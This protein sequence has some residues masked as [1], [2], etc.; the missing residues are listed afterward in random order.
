MRII[1]SFT[2]VVQIFP[3]ICMAQIKK[4]EFFDAI[5]YR[6]KPNLESYG[7]KKMYLFYEEDLM[8]SDK[9]Q[10][11]GNSI[12]YGKIKTA[13]LRSMVNSNFP[14]CLDVESWQLDDEN[15]YNS[16]KIYLKILN[17]FKKI[18]KKSK[19]GFFGVFPMDSPHADYNFDSPIRESIIMPKWHES[20]NYVKDI[21]KN[22]DV[23]FPV[24]YTR[25]KDEETWKKIVVE[26]VKKI[27][28]VNT[29]AK[30][31]GFIWPQY[32]MDDGFYKFI[33]PDVWRRELEIV[34][35]YCDGAI[36]WSHY[37]GEDGQALDFNYEMDWFKVTNQFI[38]EMNIKIK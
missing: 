25:V 6:N 4:F 12:N 2:L 15:R 18:N 13:A 14:V 31:Y 17:Y 9:G 1:L 19:M 10:N 26:K 27:R 24:F 5:L 32:Y 22:V 30:I 11:G 20:N 3:L 29:K 7:Y 16:K 33:E 35:K 38:S 37:L 21:G 23:Y 28:E 34:F 36:I 8:N